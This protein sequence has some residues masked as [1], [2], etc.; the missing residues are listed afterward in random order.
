MK[1]I[2]LS[3]DS[4][5]A[6]Y[7]VPD[8][9]ADNLMKYINDFFDWL[10]DKNNDHGYWIHLPNSSD[11]GVCYTE[12]A[13]IKWINDFIIIDSEKSVL[14]EIKESLSEEEKTYPRFNF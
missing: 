9:I 5:P 7:F 10:Y 14:I 11:L 8:M 4:N 6:I 1:K 2:A 3:A 13:F 12:E